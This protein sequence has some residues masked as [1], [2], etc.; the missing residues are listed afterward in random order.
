MKQRKTQLSSKL[1]RLIPGGTAS[2]IGG[3]VKTSGEVV[4][5]PEDIAKEL[6]DHWEK[7]FA[8]KDVDLQIME[9]WLGSL[10]HL[11]ANT[12]ESQEKDTTKSRSLPHAKHKWELTQ[13]N[14]ASHALIW[15]RSPWP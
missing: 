11:K 7:T 6:K 12:A 14:I 15:Q 4:T 13:K 8:S 1:K 9:A 3:I 2:S 5:K 10:P